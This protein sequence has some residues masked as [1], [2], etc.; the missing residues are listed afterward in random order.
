MLVQVLQR[1]AHKDAPQQERLLA[2]A[3]QRNL[4]KWKGSQDPA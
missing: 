1:A 3:A 4:H 2:E